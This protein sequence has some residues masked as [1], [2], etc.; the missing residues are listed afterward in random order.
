MEDKKSYPDE[1]FAWR[2]ARYSKAKRTKLPNQEALE[3]C[4]RIHREALTHSPPL[5][6]ETDLV[7]APG[8]TPAG[9][10]L[11][12]DLFNSKI[13]YNPITGQTI[14][15]GSGGS[16]TLNN[17]TCMVDITKCLVAAAR[18][19]SCGECTFCRVGTTRIIEI[20]ERICAGLGEMSDLELLD[21]LAQKISETSLCQVGKHAANPVKST[22]K[23]HKDQYLQHIEKHTCASG[24]CS[25][26]TA[27]Q[28]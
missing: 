3:T 27:S 24:K 15:S 5:E 16:L 21:D 11:P 1:I 18:A 7:T 9:E 26:A 4:L 13:D 23:Y 28:R 2:K 17:N 19:D 25:L 8:S 20:L 6:F 14:L 22:L 12:V 10:A